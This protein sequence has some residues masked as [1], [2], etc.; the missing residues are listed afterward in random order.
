MMYRIFQYRLPING[1]PDDLNAW[2]SSHRVVAVNQHLVVS[3]GGHLLV[4]VVPHR[5][6]QQE[7]RVPFVRVPRHGDAASPDDAPSYSLPP[8]GRDKTAGKTPP[9]PET[10][11]GAW[12]NGCGEAPRFPEGGADE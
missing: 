6:P 4:F 10:P 2:L 9:H 7:Q 11:R 1:Q 3:P 5:Q 8:A 12:R